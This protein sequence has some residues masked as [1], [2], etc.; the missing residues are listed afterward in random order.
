M[1]PKTR[2][3]DTNDFCLVLTPELV[4]SAYAARAIREHFRALAEETRRKLVGVVS[5]LV[6][7]SV[8]QR[9]DT[10]ITV[11]AALGSDSIR[12]EVADHAGFSTFEIPLAD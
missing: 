7:R 8:E 10:P 2:A 1:D 3:A 12:G 5:E 11:T 6:E 4:A 9:P